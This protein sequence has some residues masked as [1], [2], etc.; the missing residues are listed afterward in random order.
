MDAGRTVD[1]GRTADAGSDGGLPDAGVDAGVPIT[2]LDAG[3]RII[4]LGLVATDAGSSSELSFVVG[5][6][7]E[8]FQ[9]ELVSR[10]AGLLVL[11]VDALRSPTGT[12]LALGPD[13]QL[14]LSRSRPNVGAQAAL[15]LESDDARRE[16][17]PGTWRFRVTTS[18]ENDLPAS[19]LVSVRVFIKPRPPPGARQR[20]ALNLFFSGSAGLT[21]Q[22]APTQPRLQ[23]ALGEFR[24]RY[25]D[26]GIE[27]DPPRLLTLPPG[28]STVT[29]YFELDGGPRVGRSAQELLRQSASAPLGM[30]IFF[31]ESLVLD[32][33][34]PPGAILGVAGGLPGPTMTQGTTASGVIVLFDAARFVPRRPGD[35]DTLG[36]TLAHE[37]GHQLGLSHVFELSG[38]EDNLSDTPGQNE[39]RAEE[40]LMA[41][42][43]GDKGRLTPLQATTLR[44]NPVVRP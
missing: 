31:V 37:V 20:L 9:V 11:Q 4:D 40:N 12:M 22:S 28:F 1:A 10:S 42:F 29:G 36:N 27:L 24:E 15:V 39:P 21:A 8:G 19:A 26:A 17:V 13:A 38:D 41:P 30:N 25:L 34:I 44:R 7:D 2:V 23:Q 33:R 16:F 14:H 43:S 5:P 6:D 35:V 32:P 3:V 18:D